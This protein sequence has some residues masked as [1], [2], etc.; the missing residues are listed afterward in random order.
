[1]EAVSSDEETVSLNDFNEDHIPENVFENL[2]SGWVFK[3]QC[4]RDSFNELLS[5]LRERDHLDLPKDCRTLLGTPRSVFTKAQ[6][7]GECIYL[8]VE[9]GITRILHS[10]DNINFLKTLHLVINIDGIPLFK[11]SN[12]QL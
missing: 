6:S 3:H 2:L 11:C 8:G 12:T 5:I 10:I 9:N 4:S 1:M 7:G